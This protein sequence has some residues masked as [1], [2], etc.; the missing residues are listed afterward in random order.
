[1][2]IESEKQPPFFHGILVELS[3]PGILTGRV[4][5]E[6]HKFPD[7]TSGIAFR[8]DGYRAEAASSDHSPG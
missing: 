6:F 1:M 8:L 4:L 2:Q 3:I 7:C 5:E